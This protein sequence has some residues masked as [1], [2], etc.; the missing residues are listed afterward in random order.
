M[1]VYILSLP[2]NWNYGGIL[3]QFALQKFLND[4]GLSVKNYF[5]EEKVGISY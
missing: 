4:M 2:L 5:L 1:K 3:Q